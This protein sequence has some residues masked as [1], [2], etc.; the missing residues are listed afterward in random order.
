MEQFVHSSTSPQLKSSNF[1]TTYEQEIEVDEQ[2]LAELV[3]A[4]QLEVPVHIHN[5][6]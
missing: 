6:T 1:D 3:P 4:Y 2:T 5:K